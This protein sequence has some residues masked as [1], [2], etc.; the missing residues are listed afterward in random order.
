MGDTEKCRS[1]LPVTFNTKDIVHFV[2]LR[3]FEL[4]YDVET[5]VH[6][7]GTHL[8]KAEQ[9]ESTSYFMSC[10]PPTLQCLQGDPESSE[11]VYNKLDLAHAT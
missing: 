10:V 2:F 9:R 5:V 8:R 11:L 7:H 4:L 6:R 3:N 1:R